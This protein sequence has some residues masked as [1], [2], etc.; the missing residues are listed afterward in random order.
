MIRCDE[1]GHE[2]PDGTT[3]C[4]SC[5]AFLEWTG[6]AAPS[7]EPASADVASPSG[8][9]S[10]GEPK[11]SAPGGPGSQ[12]AP[13]GAVEPADTTASSAAALSPGSTESQPGPP[14][15]EPPERPGAEAPSEPAAVAAPEHPAQ[16]QPPVAEPP[17]SPAPSVKPTAEPAASE[18]VT[19]VEPPAPAVPTPSEPPTATSGPPAAARVEATPAA[20]GGTHGGS[21]GGSAADRLGRAAAFRSEPGHRATR[22]RRL[23]VDR[24]AA[25]RH[26]CGPAPERASGPTFHTGDRILRHRHTTRR[27][28]RGCGAR[29]GTRLGGGAVPRCRR[30][31]NR[32]SRRTIGS[33]SVSGAD[34]GGSRR[35]VGGPC[36]GRSLDTVERSGRL[37]GRSGGRRCAA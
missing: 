3:F 22:D 32:C 36:C 35:G 2:N 11:A 23:P 27:E 26:S 20:T 18:P 4:E 17:S 9:E 10:P 24:A 34:T 5:H 19:S 15:V 29:A 6:K 13:A 12:P 1:C 33:R 28:G 16:A 37:V 7:S 21:D 30:R 8:S 31:G 14:S 25:A